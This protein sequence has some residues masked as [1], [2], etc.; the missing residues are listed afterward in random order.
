MEAFI[1]LRKCVCGGRGIWT[2]S[3][4]CLDN[5]ENAVITNEIKTSTAEG[6]ILYSYQYINISATGIVIR[7]FTLCSS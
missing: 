7:C 5:V 4:Y 1:F 3:F 2:S 6:E